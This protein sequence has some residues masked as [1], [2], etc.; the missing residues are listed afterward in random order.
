MDWMGALAGLQADGQWPRLASASAAA[1]HRCRAGSMSSSRPERTTRNECGQQCV[2]RHHRL[3][4]LPFRWA[5]VDAPSAPPRR[6]RQ[7]PP[8][9]Y[10]VRLYADS[11]QFGGTSDSSRRTCR[12]RLSGIASFA[13]ADY[14]G[15]AR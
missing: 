15:E 5:S 7:A 14:I 3:P 10:K 11:T 12:A 13:L 4:V 1:M 6:R 8:R 2:R 9:E